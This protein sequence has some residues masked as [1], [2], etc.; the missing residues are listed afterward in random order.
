[1]SSGNT[2]LGA[3]LYSVIETKDYVSVFVYK[4]TRESSYGAEIY[5]LRATAMGPNGRVARG[6]VF[7]EPH[8]VRTTPRALHVAA[9][10]L[11]RQLLRFAE[12]DAVD[13][14]VEKPRP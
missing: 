5:E 7:V 14:L 4:H 9:D 8:F 11:A 2:P 12:D 6:R 10:D 13:L 3:D 1:M